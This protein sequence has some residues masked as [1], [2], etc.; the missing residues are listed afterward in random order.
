[1]GEFGSDEIYD[2]DDEGVLSMREAQ[3]ESQ[4]R[5]R[6]LCEGRKLADC[7]SLLIDDLIRELQTFMTRYGAICA[8][9]CG[10]LLTLM[11]ALNS[12]ITVNASV[13][14]KECLHSLGPSLSQELHKPHAIR[15]VHMYIACR[16]PCRS[17]KFEGHES[18]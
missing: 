7:T 17:A 11:P 14:C 9:M 3:Q 2:P 13:Q 10:L 18:Y 12:I 15:Y 8:P 5:I 16:P 1:M 4:R 6:A